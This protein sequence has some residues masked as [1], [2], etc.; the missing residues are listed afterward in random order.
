[1]AEEHALRD[2]IATLE[3]AETVRKMTAAVDGELRKHDL[4]PGAAEQLREL[5]LPTVGIT[6]GADGRDLFFDKD[7]TPLESVIVNTLKRPEYGHF[8]KS[9]GSPP[10][11][12]AQPAAAPGLPAPSP[13]EPLGVKV[14]RATLE[15]TAANGLR[16]KNGHVEAVRTWQERCRGKDHTHL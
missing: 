11:S 2:R 10:S 4:A 8:L 6:K 15:S 9:K 16:S 5:I 3:A 13:D 1:M 14:V 7:Y 12:P